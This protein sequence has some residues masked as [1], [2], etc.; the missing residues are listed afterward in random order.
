MKLLIA[1]GLYPPDI[2]G[3]ATYSK[4]LVEELPKHGV[5]AAVLSFG[6]VRK[7]P[8]IIRH[9]VYF[10]RVLKVGRKADIIFAQDP[11]SVGLPAML[12]AKILRKKFVLK[13]VGDYAWEQGVQRFGVRELLDIFLLK[14]DYPWQVK[15]LRWAEKLAAK[16]ADKIITP[17]DCLKTVVARWGIEAKKVSV[18]Y[19]AVEFKVVDP[20]RHDGERWIVSVGRLVPWKGFDTLIEIMPELLKQ[21]PDLKLKI[22]GDGPDF[23]KLKLQI[24]NYKLQNIVELLGEL[25][26]ER[27]LSYIHS[28]DV[29]IL[30][31][32]YEGL[33]HVILEAM[34]LD[35]PVLASN[36]GGNSELL[37]ER[38]LFAYNDKK[39]ILE[40]IKKVLENGNDYVI[41]KKVLEK[42]RLDKMTEDTKKILCGN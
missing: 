41:D 25:S 28:A 10:F 4:T 42:F 32:G 1:T 6:S 37:N 9:L 12:A 39:E 36:T 38:N 7:L 14:K 23:K 26:H 20:I 15:L 35:V 3:P 31:S 5:E 21:F 40:K 18:I 34:S 17:G 29:F 24:V 16:K 27:T 19:N 30:N 2:G 13:I 8:K 22:V 33:S 11:I